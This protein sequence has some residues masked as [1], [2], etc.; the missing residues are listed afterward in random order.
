MEGFGDGEGVCEVD[1]EES[2][3]GRSTN[4]YKVLYNVNTL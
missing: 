2:V 3:W 1:R 4:V